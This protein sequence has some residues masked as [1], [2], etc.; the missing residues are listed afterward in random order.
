MLLGDCSLMFVV[1]VDLGFVDVSSRM[2]V[3]DFGVCVYLVVWVG[4]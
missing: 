2:R 4:F 3:Y 1:C